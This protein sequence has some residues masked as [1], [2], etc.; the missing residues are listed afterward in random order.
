MEVKEGGGKEPIPFRVEDG[1]LANPADALATLALNG[2]KFVP[3]KLLS[4]VQKAVIPRNVIRDA[5]PNS[6]PFVPPV[7][8]DFSNIEMRSDD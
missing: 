5:L 4:A 3:F 1:R 6:I 8:T 2:Q 7:S